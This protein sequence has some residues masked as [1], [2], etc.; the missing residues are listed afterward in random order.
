MV[1]HIIE[2]VDMQANG[3]RVVGSFENEVG[4]VNFLFDELRN[5][6]ENVE[7]SRKVEIDVQTVNG[8][9][10]LDFK[11]FGAYNI[12]RNV[13]N[14]VAKIY[15]TNISKYSILINA[16]F[17]S[18]PTS[19]GGSDDGIM[20]VVMLEVIRKLCQWNGELRYNLIFLFNGA[21][22]SPLQAAHGFITQHKWAKT[23]K[24]VINLEA[25]GSGSKEILFQ[26]GPGHS[27]LLNYYS[28]VPHPY[29]QV[30][31]EEIFQSNIIPSDTDFR[32]FRDYGKTVGFD[33]A[34][35]KNGYK[36]HTNFD[37]VE[38]I[39]LTSYQHVGDNVLEL[40]KKIANAPEVEHINASFGKAVYFDVFG[41]FM[42]WYEEYRGTIINLVVIILSCLVAYKSFLDFK[43][44]R[45][46]KSKIYLIVTSLVLLLS[47]VFTVIGIIGIS[48]LIDALNYSMS[49]Y[50]SPFLIF[51][52]YVV[53]T[54]ML[55]SIPLIGWN[56][57]NRKLHFS[58]RVQSQ[59]QYSVVR[60]IW[61]V[62]LL[63]A[64]CLN[65]RSA[66]VVMIPVLCN[67]VGSV[68]IHLTKL[69]HSTNGWKVAYMLFN[70]FPSMMIM[71]QS[72]IILSLFIP[73]TGRI[74]NDKN[75]EMILGIISM[76]LTIIFSSF[77]MHFLTM[78][79][80]PFWLIYFFLVIFLLHFLI[81][82]TPLGFPYSENPTSPAPQRFMIYHTKRTF[83]NEKGRMKQD[84]GYFLINLDRHSPGSVIPYVNQFGKRIP[85][86]DDCKNFL[87]CGLPLFSPRMLAVMESS[88]WIPAEEPIIKENIF[89]HLNSKTMLKPNVV[90]CNFTAIGPD[91]FNVYFSPKTNIRLVRISLDAVIPE[92]VPI[93]NGRPLYFVN[94]VW[95]LSKSP[96][97]FSVDLEVPEDW[98]TTIMDIAISGKYVHNKKHQHTLQFQAFLSDFPKW[99][100]IVPTI[101]NFESWEI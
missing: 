20:C 11:P 13:Q 10:Y 25:A 50:G 97:E 18:V 57:F 32:I 95:G 73:I 42:V 63:I 46:W 61:T 66:Y 28:K 54:V 6:T 22:E 26:S 33:I 9:Y 48:T 72:V 51:G 41:L 52:L 64:T 53:P 45:S 1:F 69:H 90:T 34:F 83:N 14:V 87:V 84:A 93:W 37:D 96:L 4:A 76:S 100:N 36:Y 8:S 94:F 80:K 92:N 98:N 29:G 49:W 12:Y 89:L 58:T 35:F 55:S 39:P 65:I 86:T 88:T 21:E 31:G 3:S 77:Y 43:L 30:A 74:G 19:P 44:G 24:V 15:A 60:L 81:I 2:V 27:W 82:V 78:M 62:L 23:V 71:Y 75:P 38:S 59:L 79:K 7:S 91:H 70:A 47:W 67:T 68:F 17:D 99:T 101:A 16:H 5:I 56:H 40:V 85:I